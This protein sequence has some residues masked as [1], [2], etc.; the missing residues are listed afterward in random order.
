MGPEYGNFDMENA[1]KQDENL[2]VLESLD[3]MT[4][5]AVEQQSKKAASFTI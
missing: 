5:D 1:E 4:D 2:S 3:N